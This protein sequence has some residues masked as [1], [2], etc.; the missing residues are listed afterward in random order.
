[1]PTDTRAPR[2]AA[3]VEIA[4]LAQLSVSDMRARF[5]E[6]KQALLDHFRESRPSGPSAARLLRV[7][8]RHV[9]L[10]LAACGNVRA[11]PSWS[12]YSGGVPVP[13]GDGAR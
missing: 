13:L 2:G 9:V 8:C 4:A 10:S 5:K 6:G 1:M 11:Q 12:R 3:A 7:L